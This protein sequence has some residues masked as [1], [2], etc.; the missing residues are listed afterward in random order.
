MFST[1]N[2]AF[3]YKGGKRRYFNSMA[4]DS[5][6]ARPRADDRDATRRSLAPMMAGYASALTN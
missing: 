5:S 3:D 6:T 4:L 1:F 2:L